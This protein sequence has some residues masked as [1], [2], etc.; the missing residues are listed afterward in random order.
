MVADATSGVAS[1]VIELRPAG[2]AWQSLETTLGGGRLMARIDDAELR[3]GA[4]ELRARAVDAAG[5]AAI[6]MAGPTALRRRS[7][8]RCA[9]RSR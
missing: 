1:G 4:Y 7:R 2:G 5:N 8:S 3:A 9:A 6:G